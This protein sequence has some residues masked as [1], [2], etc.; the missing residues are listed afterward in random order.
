M[1]QKVRI[2]Q[3]ADNQKFLWPGMAGTWIV[4]E[5]N[6]RGA[7]KS[8]VVMNEAGRKYQVSK[9]LLVIPAVE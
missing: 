8:F 3:L 6:L 7:P 5:R 2:R 4:V 9:S 1:E